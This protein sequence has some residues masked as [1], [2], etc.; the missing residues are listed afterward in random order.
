MDISRFCTSYVSKC[1]YEINYTCIN[2]GSG[3]SINRG[4]SDDHHFTDRYRLKFLLNVTDVD[5]ITKAELRLYK[6]PRPRESHHDITEERVDLAIIKHP[7]DFG[8]KYWGEEL[9]QTVSSQ[10]ITSDSEGYVI[11]NATYAI[12]IWLEWDETNLFREIELEVRIRCPESMF[13]QVTPSIEFDL[14]NNKTTQL[15]IQYYQQRKNSKKRQ[16]RDD[17]DSEYCLSHPNEFRCCLRPLEINFERDFNWRW[18]IQPKS[19]PVNYCEGICPYNWGHYGYHSV[20]QELLRRRNP[21][22]APVPCCAPNKF[23]PL[24][25][26]FVVNGSIFIHALPD[27]Q[28][29]ACICR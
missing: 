15:V 18:I 25:I 17:I 11:F 1:P 4:P 6:R 9:V 8:Q 22:A 14:E 28:V 5:L 26:Q 24:M 29:L 2:L 13:M 23:K 12:Q 7:E 19:I 27:V 10:S 20:F 21:T 16:I 3:D